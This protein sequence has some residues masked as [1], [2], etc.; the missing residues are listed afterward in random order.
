MKKNLVRIV[1]V[2]SAI[3]CFILSLGLFKY[4]NYKI[5][6]ILGVVSAICVWWYIAMERT[7]KASEKKDDGEKG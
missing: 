4:R 3:G 1:A 7:S 2:M 6:C 5:S